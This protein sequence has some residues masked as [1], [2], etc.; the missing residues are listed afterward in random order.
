MLDEDGTVKVAD[1]GLAK[2]TT[3]ESTLLTMSHVTMGTPDFMAPEALK[4]ATHADHRADIYSVGVTL[5]EMLTGE[6]PRG[7]F[8]APSRAVPGLDKRLDAVVDRAL[9]T[10]PDARYPDAADLR[11]AVEPIRRSIAKR[12]SASGAATVSRNMP[13]LIGVV[14]IVLAAAAVLTHF[15][16]RKSG[17]TIPGPLAI[18]SPN[19]AGAGTGKTTLAAAATKDAPFVNTLGQ[20]FVPVPGTQ[21]LFCRWETR[22]RDY[23]AFALVND[24]K[25]AWTMAVKD[26]VPVS[27]KPEDPVV[28][29]SWD[30]ANAFCTWLTKK[31]SA[32]GRLPKGMKYRLPTDEEWSRAVGLANEAGATAK[33]RLGTN[34]VDFPW[35][36]GFPPPNNMVGNYADSAWLET[37]PKEQNKWIEGYTDGFATT[38]P[39]GSF[40]PNACGIYDLGGNVW[41]WCEDLFDP[42]DTDRVVRGASWGHHER[43]GLLSAYRRP[44]SPGTRL[45]NYGFRCVID[46]SA[47]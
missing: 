12:A 23:A 27:Q 4:G 41:E 15:A 44:L 11:T 7:R 20:E 10:E 42:R 38:A 47:R 21:V 45:S 36:T 24:V 19:P 37:F 14:V 30:D 32:E 22:V 26:G 5:Y 28:G 29:V 8:I 43:A 18:A 6:I 3:P 17:G 16:R 1:F 34:G 13:L 25:S 2:F 33:Q 9:Q 46:A 31:E 40:A 35:G 39:V